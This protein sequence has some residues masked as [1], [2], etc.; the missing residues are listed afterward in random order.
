LV[1]PPRYGDNYVSQ[2]RM[3]LRARRLSRAVSS[4]ALL[5][6]YDLCFAH[7]TITIAGR[8]SAIGPVDIRAANQWSGPWP[9]ANTA[10]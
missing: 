1:I 4:I 10:E 7:H 6:D 2:L 9:L 5:A 3:G 8:R